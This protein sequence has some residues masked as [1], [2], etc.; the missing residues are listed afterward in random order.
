MLWENASPIWSLHIFQIE[1]TARASKT[2][3][4]QSI[5]QWNKFAYAEKYSFYIQKIDYICKYYVYIIK[6]V[7]YKYI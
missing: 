6:Y 4:S 5:V 2:M 7:L 3:P 1:K